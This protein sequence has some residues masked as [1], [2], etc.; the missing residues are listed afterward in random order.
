[1]A[2][3]ARWPCAEVAELRSEP[4]CGA[5]ALLGLVAPA[6]SVYPAAAAAKH[7]NCC[8]DSRGNP[9]EKPIEEVA[10]D[11]KVEGQQRFHLIR[12][13]LGSR[14]M[15]GELDERR[16]QGNLAAGPLRAV[17][18]ERRDG[19]ERSIARA[20][21]RGDERRD[22]LR[23]VRGRRPRR[24]GGRERRS[25]PRP[26]RLDGGVAP[27][28]ARR[29]R[30]RAAATHAVRCRSSAGARPLPPTVPRPRRR[31]RARGRSPTRAPGRCRGDGRP[32]RRGSASSASRRK[33]AASRAARRRRRARDR[34]GDVFLGHRARQAERRARAGGGGRLRECGGATS[35]AATHFCR[36]R[37]VRRCHRCGH[38]NPE[39]AAR[40]AR[41]EARWRARRTLL[42]ARQRRPRP[43]HARARAAT[44]GSPR[45][46]RRCPAPTRR[47][48]AQRARRGKTGSRRA[49]LSRCLRSAAHRRRPPPRQTSPTDHA[50]PTPRIRGRH[51]R[52]A[53]R[54]SQRPEI[55]RA[56]GRR[57]RRA[58]GS[59]SS[60]APPPPR[61]SAAP[62]ISRRMR[63]LIFCEEA[64][65]C[66]WGRLK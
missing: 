45:W 49:W 52:T 3:I 64:P 16:E 12:I 22:E 26:S 25:R 31:P 50:P 48:R 60:T 39:A 53:R 54:R 36:L 32:G 15:V 20:A 40:A 17:T 66:S 41:R 11:V 28:L 19:R 18:L 29:Q 13:N 9:T 47:R 10:E 21:R 4:N 59:A 34:D 46:R 5:L 8:A 55:R 63:S 42:A 24:D 65:A 56:C 33:R 35:S 27:F 37:R 1:M 14:E 62:P 61:I 6:R 58:C 38:R 7:T 30:G 2:A 51:R 23:V 43:R 44:E 57:H